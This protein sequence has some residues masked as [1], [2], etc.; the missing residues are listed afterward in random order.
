MLLMM[1]TTMMK[2]TKDEV[3]D[4]EDEDTVIKKM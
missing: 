2:I 1:T 4:N 3:E